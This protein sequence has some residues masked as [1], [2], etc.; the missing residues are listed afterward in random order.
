MLKSLTI[1]N[2]ALIHKLEMEFGKGLIVVTG[3]TGAGKSIMLGAVNLI[4]G[5]RADTSVI[6][7]KEEKCVIEG[8]FDITRYN[9]KSFFEDYDLD[10]YNNTILR[11]EISPNGRSRAFINDTPVNLKEMKE[12]GEKLLNIHSQHETII[13][14]DSS[15]QMAIIDSYAK[16]NDE[17]KEYQHHF[18]NHNSII[19][20]LSE[21]KEKERK[22][23]TDQ[24][25]FQFQIDEL[26]AAGLKEG[27]QTILENELKL[28]NNSEEIKSVFNELINVLDNSDFAVI[29]SMKNIL[30]R[31]SKLKGISE[32]IDDII[33]RI[34]SMLIDIQDISREADRIEEKVEIDHKRVEHL[35][36]RLDNIYSLQQKHN[37]SGIN[38]LLDL[39]TDFENR[40]SDIASLENETNKLDK[41]LKKSGEDLSNLAASLSEKRRKIIPVIE[42]EVLGKISQLGMSGAEFK[43]RYDKL[44]DFGKDGID[45]IVFM[46]NAN[47][48]GELH[49]ISKVASGGELSRLMLS[50]K[51]MIAKENLIPTIIFDEIDSGVSG[52]I[53]GKVGNILK[54]MGDF[55]QVIAITHLPQIAGMGVAHYKVYK[56]IDETKTYSRIKLLNSKE[57]IDEM[58]QLIS[59]E[60]ITPQAIDAAKEL[61]FTKSKN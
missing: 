14:N 44:D 24:D 17:L 57:R 22:A 19:K 37:V 3:E 5:E 58:A 36:E 11:R 53:A 26:N 38:D 12:L 25:Y 60:R 33:N 40:I 51:S 30:S 49:K 16:T 56:E 4:L 52:D 27:E 55:M 59:G 34:D 9:L 48:G 39:L 46:F 41:A 54:S 10:Y 43:I 2:Y 1:N 45:M 18:R 42:K 23:K 28:L 7:N 47:R 8:K 32:E 6:F 15:F 61:L 50:M 31:I 13:L 29:S 21:L 20:K 35:T